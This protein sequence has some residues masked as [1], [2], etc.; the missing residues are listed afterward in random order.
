[1]QI[2]TS[3]IAGLRVHQVDRGEGPTVIL[4]HG[5]GAPGTDL[6]GLAPALPPGRY[7]FPEAPLA[8][9]PGFGM[10][11]AWWMLDTARLQEAMIRGVP[12]DLSS[13]YPEA[14]CQ[15]RDQ[16]VEMI[17][18]LNL[19]AP[20]ILG[21]FSQGA[22]LSCEVALRSDVELAG[23]VLLSGNLVAKDWWLPAMGSRAGLS[24]FQSHG[25]QDA[26]LSFVGAEALRDALVD[27]GVEVT[28]HGFSG[29]HEIPMSVIE[30]LRTF[31]AR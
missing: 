27:G 24:V 31:L 5:F 18:A 15:V 7:V 12:R 21:G 28:F 29:G 30:S 23:L 1:M 14:L 10:G 22:M 26:V 4:L 3:E 17:G 13:E 11:R 16:L 25:R 2:D 6:L 20:P 8:L 19:N 9:P